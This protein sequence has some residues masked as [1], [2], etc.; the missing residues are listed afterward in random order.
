MTFAAVAQAMDDAMICVFEA[1]YQYNFWRPVTAIRNGDIDGND[2]TQREASWTGFIDNPLHPEYP[3][4]HSILASAVA[5]VL[6]AEVGRGPVPVL[7]TTS[8]SAKGAARSWT[9]LD[10]FTR[11]VADARIYEGV[12]Y[13]TSTDVGIA[14]GKQIGDLAVQKFLRA[15]H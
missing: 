8:P 11:E 1:K 15:A 3:S 4:A 13:R 9:N 2:A 14:M 7:T 12:H 5:T 10:E 6:K